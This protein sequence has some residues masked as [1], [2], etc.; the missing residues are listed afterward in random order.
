MKPDRAAGESAKA[1]CDAIGSASCCVVCPLSH[2][3][4]GA[5]ARVVSLSGAPRLR[6]KLMALGLRPSADLAVLGRA[7]GH[8]AMELRAGTVHLMLRAD[9]ARDV[10]V[11]FDPADARHELPVL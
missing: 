5:C 9:E 7:A 8:G 1:G 4:R 2:L 10:L 6:R 3:A 11:E